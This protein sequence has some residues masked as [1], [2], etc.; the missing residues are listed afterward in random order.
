MSC[1]DMGIEIEVGSPLLGVES[2][3]FVCGTG[4][5]FP[6]GFVTSATIGSPYHTAEDY[7]GES[8]STGSATSRRAGATGTAGGGK[9]RAP[10][11]G[12][13]TRDRKTEP[14]AADGNA[15]SVAA[16]QSTEPRG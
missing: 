2:L 3:R 15:E 4:R 6:E 9:A 10:S 1:K 11:N 8:E 7:Y 12:T 16:E 14:T 13:S 5:P